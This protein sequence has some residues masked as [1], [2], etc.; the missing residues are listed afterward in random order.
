MDY[1]LRRERRQRANDLINQQIIEQWVIWL[2]FI[3]MS[4]SYIYISRAIDLERQREDDLR[5]QFQSIIHD[6]QVNR[7]NDFLFF[8]L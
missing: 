6:V 5:R 7:S 4:I 1:L 2:I 3:P 8:K